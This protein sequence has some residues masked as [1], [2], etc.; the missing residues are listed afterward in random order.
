MFPPP[1]CRVIRL[2]YHRVFKRPLWNAFS[3]SFLVLIFNLL[4]VF[5][6]KHFFFWW[7]ATGG[8]NSILFVR[9]LKNTVH[10]KNIIILHWKL[11]VLQT[12]MCHERGMIASVVMAN[13][14]TGVESYS[15]G[16]ISQ[17][18]SLPTVPF[19][20]HSITCT[21]TDGWGPLSKDK[22]GVISPLA[23][24]DT[25]IAFGSHRETHTGL[26]TW[27]K[28]DSNSELVKRPVN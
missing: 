15:R 16:L 7:H 8:F 19:C 21:I 3:N 5:F 20:F 27:L 12:P 24:L 2:N 23:F 22:A 25:W 14:F 13:I 4:L 11:K 9:P 1:P 17:T 28:S 26:Q 6:C 10:H 18:F